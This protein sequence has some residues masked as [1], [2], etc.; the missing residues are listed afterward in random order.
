[1]QRQE[2]VGG[3]LG[4]RREKG[5]QGLSWAMLVTTLRVSLCASLPCDFVTPHSSVPTVTLGLLATKVIALTVL[6]S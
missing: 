2:R 5:V 6:I 4:D 3:S 1:M